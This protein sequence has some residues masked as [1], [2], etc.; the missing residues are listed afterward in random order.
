[1][2]DIQFVSYDGKFPCRC[3]GQLVLLIDGKKVTFGR[4]GE[5]EDFWTSGGRVWF[6]DNW[7]DHV[8]HGEWRLTNFINGFTA[9][10]MEKMIEIFNK[11]VPY[12]CCGGCV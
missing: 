7:E 1:M 9:E 8:E 10:E 2:K 4:G 6:S 5:Y 3:S 11:N 12:G